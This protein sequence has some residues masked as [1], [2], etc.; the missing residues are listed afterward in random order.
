MVCPQV[1]Y[2]A[3]VKKVWYGWYLMVLRMIIL[4]VNQGI[5]KQYGTLD[6]NLRERQICI[7]KRLQGHKLLLT[8]LSLHDFNL[9]EILY[10]F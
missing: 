10:M 1:E 9:E 3:A 6:L 5:T 2:H 4:C 7:K 8:V